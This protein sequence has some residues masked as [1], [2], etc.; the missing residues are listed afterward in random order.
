M[1][2]TAIA[3]TTAATMIVVS[4]GPGDGVGVGEALGMGV[5]VGVGLG[6]ELRVTV[7]TVEFTETP[8]LSATSAR[9]DQTPNFADEENGYWKLA[10]LALGISEY[11]EPPGV[12]RNHWYK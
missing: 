1:A 2:S 3:T 7:A 5:G 9:N 12:S 6:G 11:E 4:D 8:V 10:E